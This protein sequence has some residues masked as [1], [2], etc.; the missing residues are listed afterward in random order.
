MREIQANCELISKESNRTGELE[1][2]IQRNKM[3]QDSLGADFR[4]SMERIQEDMRR[5]WSE[6]KLK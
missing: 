2:R 5:V 1:L 4:E 3:L 6:L